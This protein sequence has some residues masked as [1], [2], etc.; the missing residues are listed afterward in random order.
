MAASAAGLGRLAIFLHALSWLEHRDEIGPEQGHSQT[1][2]LPARKPDQRSGDSSRAAGS[3]GRGSQEQGQ[4]FLATSVDFPATLPLRMVLDAVNRRPVGVGQ[5]VWA[6]D[7]VAR[8]WTVLLE[9][10]GG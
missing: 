7:L 10:G 1:A 9:P 8:E 2:H 5:G 4:E 6:F 3:G